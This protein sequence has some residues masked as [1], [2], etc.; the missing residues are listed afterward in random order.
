[1]DALI[2]DLLAYSRLVRAEISLDTV[3]LE[4]VVDEAVGAL[5]MELKERGGEIVGRAAARAACRPTGP[6][7]ARS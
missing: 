7:S 5:E 2:Q 1:M 4:T 6:C 3:S